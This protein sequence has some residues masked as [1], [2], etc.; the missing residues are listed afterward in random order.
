M[1]SGIIPTASQFLF[2][3]RKKP[4]PRLPLDPRLVPAV[5]Q[6]N[7]AE[8]RENGGRGAFLPLRGMESNF[9]GSPLLE[10]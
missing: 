8:I 6:E 1:A 2:K 5:F 3:Y 9:C 10:R 7:K 4:L